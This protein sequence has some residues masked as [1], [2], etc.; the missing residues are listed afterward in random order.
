MGK[1]SPDNLLIVLGDQLDEGAASLAELNPRTDVV[2][3]AEASAEAEYV[4]SHKA[5]IVLFL[6]AMR[7]FRNRLREL[8]FQVRYHALGDS[9]AA[10]L[11]EIL[12][13]DLRILTPKRGL[14]VR[15]GEFRLVEELRTACRRSRLDLEIREDGHF[16]CSLEEFADWT[17]ARKTL[18]LEHFYR[19]MR[20]RADVM[21]DNGVP[22]GRKWNHDA[23]NRRSLGRNGPGLVPQP[24]AFDP[25][26]ITREAIRRVEQRFPQHPG[27]LVNFDWPVTRKQAIAALDDFIAHRLPTFGPW[28]DA[29]WTSQPYLHHARLS[30]ALNLKLLDPREVIGRVETAYRNGTVDVASAE[31]FIRQVLGW[32]EYVRGIY[33]R[34]M[35][36]YLRLNS[37]DAHQPLPA[38]YWSGDTDMACLHACINQTMEYGYAHHI[39]RL[40]VTGLFALLL[41]VK[42]KQ[43]HAWYLSVYVDA[44]EW[45]ELP[46]TLGMSQ[47]ADG[48]IL[49]SK[50]Y[51]ASGNHIKRMSNY[52][53]HCRYNP[54]QPVGEDACPFTALYWDFLI[55]HRERFTNHPR[56]GVQWRHLWRVDED[57]RHEIRISAETLRN[58]LASKS[59]IA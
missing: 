12:L 21:L 29:M 55:R 23:S 52:C 42:P 14:L 49:T 48:G 9:L 51:V 17:E 4:W 33:W 30:A 27:S 53:L 10:S 43:V 20:K 58:R 40:M 47:F 28:Q 22:A 5:R 50:P 13:R 1:R 57:R 37:L 11:G 32:R 39:Q 24:P 25:D 45:V 26:D 6:S 31:G 8:G 16:M 35:P 34:N 56:A 38:F 44:V 7:H 2:W 41:G 54:K 18:R 15:P 19:H 46:N 59:K 3:M 36:G